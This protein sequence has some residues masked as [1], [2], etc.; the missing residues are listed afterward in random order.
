MSSCTSSSSACGLAAWRST[1]GTWRR[2]RGTMDA[3]RVLKWDCRVR[4]A[5]S[6]PSLHD[7]VYVALPNVGVHDVVS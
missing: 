7:G 5:G 1:D 6:N 3:E 4:V 2:V